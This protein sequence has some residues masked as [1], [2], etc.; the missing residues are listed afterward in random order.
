MRL[1]DLIN[2]N[3]DLMKQLAKGGGITFS[4]IRQ[5]E[6]YL[7]VKNEMC[8]P[9]DITIA[10]NRIAAKHD[11]HDTTVWRAVKKMGQEC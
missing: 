11:I 5:A 1:G 2:E 10:V 3:K 9:C 4:T 6:I 7:E 8:K